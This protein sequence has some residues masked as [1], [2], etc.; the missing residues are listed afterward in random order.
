MSDYL[1]SL[2]PHT[3]LMEEILQRESE[4]T[5]MEPSL[6]Q[7]DRSSLESWSGWL[8][9]LVREEEVIKFDG[10]MGL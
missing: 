6:L 3:Q 1:L 10:L 5:L 2:Q 9:S 8:P 4:R 7:T